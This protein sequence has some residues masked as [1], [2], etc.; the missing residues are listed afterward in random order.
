MNK[1]KGKP[2]MLII[3]ATGVSYGAFIVLATVSAMSINIPPAIAV[4]GRRYR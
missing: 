2:K 1:K 4:I 3:A